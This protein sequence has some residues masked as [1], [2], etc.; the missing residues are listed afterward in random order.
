MVTILFKT[1]TVISYTNKI[2]AFNTF[3]TKI[4]IIEIIVKI[5]TI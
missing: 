3:L 2:K 5:I 1:I 4:K